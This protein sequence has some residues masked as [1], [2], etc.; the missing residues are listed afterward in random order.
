MDTPPAEGA[1]AVTVLQA[2]DIPGKKVDAYVSLKSSFNRQQFKTKVIKGTPTPSWNEVFHFY[3]ASLVG[4]VI[5]KLH[6][7]GRLRTHQIGA[8]TIPVSDASSDGKSVEKWYKVEDKKSKG[9]SDQQAQIKLKLHLPLPKDKQDKPKEK[10]KMLDVYNLT[11]VLGKGGFSVVKLGVHKQTGEQ[12]AIKIIDKEAIQL[13]NDMHLL[14]REIDIMKKLHH[15]NIIELVEVYDEEKALY[16]VMELVTGGELFDEIVKRGAYSERDAATIIQQILEAVHYMHSNGVAHRDLKPENLLVQGNSVKISDFGLSKA[17]DG[18][19]NQ[20]KTCCGT[21][22][23]AAPEVLMAQPYDNAVDIWSVGVITYI[24][25]CGFPPFYGET[26]Q[27]I[28]KKI[29]AGKFDF[30]SPDW[31]DISEDAKAFIKSML[32]QDPNQRPSASDCLSNPW[33]KGNA[34]QRT[35]SRLTS[36][37]DQMKQYNELRTKL[38]TP[39]T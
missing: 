32:T 21:P 39:T 38:K 22:D 5:L 27:D 31:D 29:L 30:P 3:N 33:I 2:K 25:L 12:F 13:K 26:D 37:R 35:L 28:F 6:D 9:S 15:K 17:F 24:L 7:K 11:K 36:L 14:Q 8:V 18:S 10:Q 16:L 23:Y 1:L 20:L 19:E 4:N 34:P